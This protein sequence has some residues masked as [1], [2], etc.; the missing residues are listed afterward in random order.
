MKFLEKMKSFEDFGMVNQFSGEGS[1]KSKS[2]VRRKESK[3]ERRKNIEAFI[4]IKWLSF[5]FPKWRLLWEL[6]LMCR[7]HTYIPHILKYAQPIRT[8][9]VGKYKIT[10][11][12]AM[13]SPR[14]QKRFR[15]CKQWI[16]TSTNLFIIIRH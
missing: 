12:R 1:R 14:S 16:T 5:L 8:L 7:A 6:H 15:F 2:L 11:V 10:T 3:R 9:T 4:A 13:S